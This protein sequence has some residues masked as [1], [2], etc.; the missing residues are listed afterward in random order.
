MNK[1]KT[2][3]QLLITALTLFLA[4]TGFA[5]EKQNDA[6]WEETIDFLIK[7]K[8]EIS[9]INWDAVYFQVQ[10]IDKSLATR[11]HIDF[12]NKESMSIFASATE[13]YNYPKSCNEE[14]SK[15]INTKN[16]ILLNLKSVSDEGY[17]LKIE[18]LNDCFLLATSY[19]N[20][21][22]NCQ[23]Q[24]TNKLIKNIVLII[25]NEETQN[26]YYKAFTHLAYLAKE[27]REKIRIESDDKF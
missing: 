26:R 11:F 25:E 14:V 5:Q 17:G 19:P 16:C 27:K 10:D 7:Y 6:T 22:K 15:S 13:E 12:I 1:P 21:K 9:G 24:K 18:F 20:W 8:N 2:M 4:T 23:L 3:K